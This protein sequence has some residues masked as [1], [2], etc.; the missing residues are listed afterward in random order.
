VKVGDTVL[1]KGK[2]VINKDLG[3]GYKY[4]VIIEDAKVT[5]E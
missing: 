4:E 1:I 3:S 2:V 5:R